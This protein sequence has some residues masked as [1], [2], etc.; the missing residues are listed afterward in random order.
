M[1]KEY[2]N[3]NI[4]FQ[5]YFRN[6]PRLIESAPAPSPHPFLCPQAENKHITTNRYMRT[7]FFCP[8]L[9]TSKVN[10]ER[11]IFQFCKSKKTCIFILLRFILFFNLS[12]FFCFKFVFLIFDKILCFL[13]QWSVCLDK[14]RTPGS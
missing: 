5:K 9:K 14:T 1:F 12:I 11:L 4:Y 8:D 13:L 7:C 3:D 10:N 2:N 6:L